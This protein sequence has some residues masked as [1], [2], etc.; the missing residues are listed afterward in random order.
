MISGG[1]NSK[2]YTGD[3]DDDDAGNA[4]RFGHYTLSLPPPH[5]Q[6]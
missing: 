2:P 5:L 6:P 1:E 4:K 3:D